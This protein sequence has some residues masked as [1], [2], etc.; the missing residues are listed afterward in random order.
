MGGPLA[1]DGCHLM[2]GHNNQ[3]NF[4]VNCEGGVREET[5]PGGTCGG[6]CPIVWGIKWREV[7]KNREI[8]WALAID[9]CRL[10]ILHTTTNHKQAAVTEGSTNG[11]RDEREVQEK[12]N[13]I[14]LGRHCS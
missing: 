1:L 13:T 2:W 5:R 9:G 7:I 6:C 8:G 12:H 3:P 4:F 10:N 14:V 11:R